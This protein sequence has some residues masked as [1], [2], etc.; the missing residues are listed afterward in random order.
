MGKRKW[1]KEFSSTLGEKARY[2]LRLDRK[3]KEITD[4]VIQLEVEV[5]GKWKPIVRYD[6]SHGYP[7]RDLY[8]A[9]GK[10][11]DAVD[12]TYDP[13]LG[14][15]NVASTAQDDIRKNW[16]RYCEGFEDE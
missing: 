9:D 12:T 7:H 10:S 2:R 1:D 8:T 6:A 15:A 4:F 5:D 3:E 14:Y 16:V 13:D 11:K